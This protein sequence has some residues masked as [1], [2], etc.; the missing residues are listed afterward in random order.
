VGKDK[1]VPVLRK[2]SPTTSSLDGV[3]EV[4]GFNVESSGT[5]GDLNSLCRVIVH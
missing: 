1:G 2:H 5:L 3:L 4:P